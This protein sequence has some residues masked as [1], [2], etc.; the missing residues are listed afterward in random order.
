[1]T[2]PI[3][4]TTSLLA[5]S[6]MSNPAAYAKANQTAATLN[7]LEWGASYLLKTIYNDTATGT[8]IIYQA[9]GALMGHGRDTCNTCVQHWSQAVMIRCAQW[10]R[11]R[12][13]RE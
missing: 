10:T 4:W 8:N 13:E 5:W 9:R 12:T 11:C 3:A 2:F 1:M 6:L 7:Q